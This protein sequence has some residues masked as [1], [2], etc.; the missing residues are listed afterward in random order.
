MQLRQIEAICN[1]TTVCARYPGYNEH[2]IYFH[3]KMQKLW[4]LHVWADRWLLRGFHCIKAY[5]ALVKDRESEAHFSL[6]LARPRVREST[7]DQS[8]WD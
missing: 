4:M 8:K 2:G 7:T 3:N 5:P 6:S 1:V